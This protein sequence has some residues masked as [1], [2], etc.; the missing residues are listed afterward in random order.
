MTNV[1]AAH[2]LD[3]RIGRIERGL[4]VPSAP[5]SQ[6]SRPATLAE[7]MEFYKVPGLSIAV[8][9]NYQVD[10]ARAH[11]V[12]EAGGTEPVTT[13]TLFQGGSL[14]KPIVAL[15][16]LR[17]VEEGRLSLEADVNTLLTSWR[18]PPNDAWEPRRPCCR[19][20][21]A[22]SRRGRRPSGSV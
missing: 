1:D 15:A 19:S 21:R 7:R 3:Q 9:N 4:V 2:D 13:R 6:E 16:A 14:G 12:L 10:W 17:L 5:G 22:R 11:G 20:C 8:I 18:I